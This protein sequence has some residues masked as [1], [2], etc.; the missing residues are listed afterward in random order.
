MSK[1]ALPTIGRVVYFYSA[2]SNKEHAAIVADVVEG[3]TVSLGVFAHGRECSC[4]NAGAARRR[5]RRW[6]FMVGLDAV[7]KGTGPKDRGARKQLGWQ[8][9]ADH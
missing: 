2:A 4:S 5:K 6:H 9:Q 3:Y 1:P 8:I 7:P